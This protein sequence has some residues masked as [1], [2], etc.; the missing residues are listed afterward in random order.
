MKRLI[1]L[2]AIVITSMSL[3]ACLGTRFIEEGEYVLF[4][5]KVKTTKKVSSDE[6]A[7]FLAQKPNR[8]ILVF[9]FSPYVFFYET[10]K[11]RYD[12]VAL[13]AKRDTLQQEFDAKIQAL[14]DKKGKEAKKLMRKRN[15]KLAKLDKQIEEGNIRMRWGEPVSVYDSSLTQK[16]VEQLNIALF[17][18]GYFNAEVSYTEKLRHKRARIIYNVTEGKAQK[19]DSLIWNIADSVL[20]QTLLPTREK[21]LIKR[22]QNYNQDR[23]IEERNRVESYLKNNGYYD[24]SKQYISFQVDT[25]LSNQKVRVIMN[26]ANPGKRGYHKVFTLDSVIFVTDANVTAPKGSKRSFRVIDNIT[27]QFFQEQYSKKILG[28]R[29]FLRPDS[30]YSLENTFN[31]QKQI[32]NLD[33][34]RFVNINYDTTGGRFIANIFTSPLPKFQTSN[35]VGVN[36]NQGFPGPFYNLS[37]KNR[38]ILGGLEILELN[39]RAGIEGVASAASEGQ[40]YQSQELG[41]NLSL[42]FPQFLFPLSNTLKLK[43]GE[44]NP[45]TR[46]QIGYNY[47]NRPE[48][49]RRTS[50]A[51]FTYN[52]QSKRNHQFGFSPGDIS[53]IDSRIQSTV[54]QEQLNELEANGNNLIQSFRPSFVSSINGYGVFNFGKYGTDQNKSSYLRIFLESGGTFSDFSDTRYFEE[55]NLIHYRFY[56]VSADFRRY[57]PINQYNTIA[58]RVNGGIA[59]PYGNLFVLPYEKYFFAGGSSSV[60]AWNPRRL[61]PGSYQPTLNDRGEFSYRIEQ[62]GEILIESSVE[63]RRKLIGFIDG[64]LFLDAGNVWSSRKIETKPGADFAVDRFYKEIALGTGFALRFDFSFLILR[65]DLAFKMYD[66]AQDEGK[67]WVIDKMRLDTK[68]N[69]GP[70][71]NIGIGYPF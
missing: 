7:N 55:R 25:S 67:R 16:S 50:K 27:Y 14:P 57:Y 60:R 13:I 70:T 18:K 28:A 20:A 10:G 19:V 8:K 31:T 23:I 5:Q 52:W 41:T 6:L 58:F 54:F 68:S 34:F 26:I 30:V 43:L 45:K 15:R 32:A 47:T 64:A 12:K 59:Q 36:V 17:N 66:P 61:G 2:L 38:N 39:F 22:G 21:S 69:F 37:F 40:L 3:S 62:P 71:L 46:L 9:P 4:K 42:T 48:Y 63:F 56:K 51:S 24:F 65:L 29:V 33:V 49:I 44:V 1:S 11:K 53:Y 35:E